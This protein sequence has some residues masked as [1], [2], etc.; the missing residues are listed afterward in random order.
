MKVVLYT[1]PT[2]EPVTLAEVRSRLHLNPAPNYA[3]GVGDQ[4][5]A[6][7]A[8][9]TYTLTVV[10]AGSVTIAAGT[11][12]GSGW[13]AATAGSP[14]TVIIATAG[15]VTLNA[16]GVIT[17]I[18]LS[19]V[20]EEDTDITRLIVEA[21]E[22]VEDLTGRA[23]ITQT[24]DCYL[25]RWPCSDRIVLPFGNLA[26]VVFVT[27]KDTVGAV[28]TLT[29]N[30]DYLVETNGGQHGAIV[31]PYG[32][33]WPNSTLYPSNPITIRYVCGY[34]LAASVPEEIKG[35]IYYHVMA[36]YTMDPKTM[37]VL[38]ESVDHKLRN[39]RL[40]TTK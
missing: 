20:L 7:A 31:L 36:N 25:E 10:G 35:A 19:P 8:A 5:C 30:I 27:Y 22:Y 15:T 33:T 34:G 3:A 26:S 6:L 21:R 29:E 38:L 40:Y 11:A 24:W 13:G 37:G 16:T 28:T 12:V 18:T 1:A 23:V 14:R 4:T 2:V 39:Y 32:N 9:G 17:S